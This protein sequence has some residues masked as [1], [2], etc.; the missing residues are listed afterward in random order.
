M[1]PLPKIGFVT[2]AVLLVALGTAGLSA[3][4]LEE[5][6][7]WWK[8]VEF[9]ASDRLEGRNTGSAGHKLAVDYV[10]GEFE[11]AGLQA[12][13]VNG[14]IQ[15]VPFAVR[16]LDEANSKVDWIVNGAPSAVAF[17]DEIT[18]AARS[19]AEKPV[20]AA[21]VFV[22]YGLVVPEQ[23][24][25]DL[26]G[27]DLKGK[28]VVKL[29]GGPK[30]IPGNLKSHYSSGAETWKFL[31]AAGAIGVISV[32]NPK[33]MDIPWPR[34][35]ESR[36][37]PSMSLADP[38]MDDTAGL[39]VAMTIN[40]S[41]A[42][43]FFEGSGHTFQ[44]ILALADSDQPLPKFPL[45]GQFRVKSAVRQSK[46]EPQ[47]V[48]ALLPGSDPALRAEYIVLSAHI[49]HLGVAEQGEGD[50]IFNGAMDNAS[51]IGWLLE[52]AR[53]VKESG[54]KPR[55]SLIFLAVTGE[56][57]GLQGSKFFAEYP[58]VKNA[59]I[60]AD[61]NMDMVLPL[62]PLRYLEVQG[63]GE[64]SLGADIRAVCEAHGVQVQF[65]K[66]PDRN[67]FIRSDQYSFVKHGIP[68]LA[69]KFG[70]I[71]GSPEEKIY[72]A[73][74]RDRYHGVKDDLQQPVD[75]EGAGK[76]TGMLFD[77]LTRVAN[78]SDRPHWNGDSFFKRFER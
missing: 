22:G 32:A 9:L 23:N 65:D 77:L 3:G 74:Y 40:P 76:F 73:W 67:R 78:E 10:A 5:G 75:L 46:V 20:T 8:H 51:G 37:H 60:V 34:I 71:P 68:S 12:A 49:D 28:V 36:L 58:S 54:L 19:D 14:Y 42:E 21:A 56:E 16:Q 4:D 50:R 66:E 15:P 11:R 33:S 7:R 27:L 24:Y 26:K 47:N 1:T 29:S 38:R 31:K 41:K 64:S 25:D 2:V 52:T 6:K 43:R 70:W 39:K 44:E 57:K 63:L 45:K 69:F 48:V 61:I 72:K 59:R 18:L 35:A 30:S 53:R 55:R 13:G 62:F 17:G